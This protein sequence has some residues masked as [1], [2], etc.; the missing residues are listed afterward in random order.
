[1]AFRPVLVIDMDITVTLQFSDE[2][3]NVRAS[4]AD[5]SEVIR[6]LVNCA[7]D[8]AK[9]RDVRDCEVVHVVIR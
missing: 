4:S 2:D 9:F 6:Q 5:F 3:V 1:M 8:Y 7:I